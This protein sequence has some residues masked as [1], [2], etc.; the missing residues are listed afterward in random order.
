MMYHCFSITTEPSV[1]KNFNCALDKPAHAAVH[2]KKIDSEKR[3]RDNYNPSG[4]KHFVPRGPGYLAHFHAHLVQK[5]AP[6]GGIFGNFLKY[7]GNSVP[8]FAA[9]ASF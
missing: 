2:A 1:R 6:A 7:R 4:H 3:H 8:A 5:S 9:P